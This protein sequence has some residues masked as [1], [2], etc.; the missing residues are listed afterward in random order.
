[1]VG[2]RQKQRRSISFTVRQSQCEKHW[3]NRIAKQSADH[4]FGAGSQRHVAQAQF[5]WLGHCLR[6]VAWSSG[7]YLVLR[8]DGWP[9]A[10]SLSRLQAA[11]QCFAIWLVPRPSRFCC[12]FAKAPLGAKSARSL[13]CGKPGSRLSRTR[14]KKGAQGLGV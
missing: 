1:M 3:H 2:A 10:W 11:K 7:W 8:R 9:S 12:S 13:C 6:R 4:H 5:K 14:Q